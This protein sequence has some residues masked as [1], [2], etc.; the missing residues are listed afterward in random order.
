MPHAASF[1]Y[2]Q[3]PED[4]RHA[5]TPI[6]ESHHTTLQVL[7]DHST[8]T[9]RSIRTTIGAAFHLT[10]GALNSR[11]LELL[12]DDR[13][14]IVTGTAGSGKSA[15]AKEVFEHFGADHLAFAFRAEEF[16]EAHLNHTLQQCNV[17]HNA[18]N[19][20]ALLAGQSRKVLLIESVERLLEASAAMRSATSLPSFVKTHPG[21]SL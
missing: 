19:L 9:L 4:L 6:G 7:F 18:E 11:L 17:H 8:T 21:E 5:H 3:L 12:E 10:R 15:I 14:V 16:A 13:V 1:T 2:D 20:F